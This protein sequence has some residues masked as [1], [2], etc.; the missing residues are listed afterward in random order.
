MPSPA[1]EDYIKTIY[2]I[3]EESGSA[4]T[5]D[6]ARAMEVTAASVTGMI[7]RLARMKLVEHESYR[8]VR[9]TSAGER[10][11]L[12]IIRHHRLLETYLR[13]VLGY[14]WAAMHE[15]AEHLEHH[16]SEDFESR[17]D[18]L[19]GFPTHDP[20]GHPIPRPD[21]TIVRTRSV[22]LQQATIDQPWVVDHVSD[23]D[24]AILDFLERIGLL[25]GQRI[26]VVAQGDPMTV[27]IEGNKQTLTSEVVGSVHVTAQE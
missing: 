21:L 24:I 1:V 4:T 5:S 6:V 25:P 3:L 20:H 16:I 14:S 8:G 23:A 15:E 10:I 2:R 18:E 7:K 22:P 13:Q 17:I 19:L 11:A 9:L 27:L 26:S 12:E